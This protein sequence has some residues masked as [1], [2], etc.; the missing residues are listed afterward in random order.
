MDN[1]EANILVV[2]D[3]SVIRDGCTRILTKEGYNVESVENGMECLERVKQKSYDLILLDLMMPG[4]SGLE[5]IQEINKLDLDI[6][7]IVITG[8]ATVETAVEAMK[9]GAYD[10][11]PKPFTPDQLRVVVKRALSNKALRLEAE[12]LREEQEKG[13]LAIAEEKSKIKTILNCLPNGILVMDADKKVALYNPVVTSVLKIANGV[14]SIGTP[15]DQCIECADLSNMISEVLDNS[16]DDA[17]I[18]SGEVT[19]DNDIP[20][21]AHVAPVKMEDGEVVGA[22]TV[23]QDIREQKAI[24]KVKADFIAKVTHELKAPVATVNQL[25]M[26]ILDGAVGDLD[27]KQEQMMTRAKK[28]GEGLIELISDLL[29]ISK[30]E[31]GIAIQRKSLTSIDSV[32]DDVVDLLKPLAD[33]KKISIKITIDKNL[34]EINVDKDGM[35]DVFTNLVSN[36]IK[37]SDDGSRIKITGKSDKDYV[38]ISVS[39]NGF[40][41][42]EKDQPNIFDRFFRVK[43]KKT[44]QIIG[45]GLGLPIVKEIVEAHLGTIDLESEEGKGSTFHV[46]L[47]KNV[48]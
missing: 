40:G 4:M 34:P 27:E 33:E 31:S 47:P 36:A 22:V 20:I 25:L 21:M 42:N 2:D 1:Y 26:T 11:V 6:N 12:Y 45:T 10:Y 5:I 44:R 37:Y 24:D 7:I 39:D 18:I 17:L 32:I 23:L 48:E 43:N 38:R 8:Y 9:S 14:N 35:K 15:V 30:I 29:N 13:L 41:I 46:S 16:S 3:E 19:G 28:R